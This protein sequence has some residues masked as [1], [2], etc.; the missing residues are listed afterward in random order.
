M[1]TVLSLLLI[2]LGGMELLLHPSALSV[3]LEGVRQ[4]LF[5]Y[6]VAIMEIEA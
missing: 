2:C 4:E 3:G 6:K 1:D 5:I